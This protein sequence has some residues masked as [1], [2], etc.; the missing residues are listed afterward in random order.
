MKKYFFLFL[1][2]AQSFMLGMY[3]ASQ[4]KFNSPIEL[5]RWGLTLFFCIFSLVV[6]LNKKNNA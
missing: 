4:F 3:T 5:H 2:F 6:F 1:F